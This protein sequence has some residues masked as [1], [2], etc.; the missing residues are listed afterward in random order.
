M[1]DFREIYTVVLSECEEGNDSM[2]LKHTIVGRMVIEGGSLLFTIQRES[3]RHMPYRAFSPGTWKEAY[4]S[5][6]EGNPVDY[7]V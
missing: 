1:S 2:L 4:L 3:G 5:D 7:K 6:E